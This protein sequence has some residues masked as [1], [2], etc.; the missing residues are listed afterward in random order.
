MKIPLRTRLSAMAVLSIAM[1]FTS[2]RAAAQG[3]AGAGAAEA[4]AASSGSHSYNPTKWFAK[5]DA[6]AADSVPVEQLDQKLELKLRAA[7]VLDANASLKNVCQNFIER[8]DCV[9]ALRASHNL[10]LNFVCVKASMTGVRTDVDA[11]SC[12]M[13]S[14]DKPLKLMKAIRF[15]KSDAD[16]KNGAKEAEAAARE[17]IKDAVAQVNTTTAQATAAQ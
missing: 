17:D 10:G 9:A 16:A 7:Q 1:L 14:D 13:P 2:G 12:R 8:A 4:A 3:P 15:L 5:K 6:K 11:S